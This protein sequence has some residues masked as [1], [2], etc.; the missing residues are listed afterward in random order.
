ME[1]V[2]SMLSHL[3][4]DFSICAIIIIIIVIINYSSLN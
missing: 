2:H 3:H 1:F 4:F